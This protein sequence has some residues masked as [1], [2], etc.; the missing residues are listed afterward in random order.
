MRYDGFDIVRWKVVNPKPWWFRLAERLIPER[1]R[2][3]P[4]AYD[5]SRGVVLR[6]VA[7]VKR[8]VYLQQ[9]SGSEHPAWAHSHQWRRTFAIGL[10]GSYLE[11]RPAWQGLRLRRAPYFYTMDD[12]VIHRVTLPSPGH[13]S[14]FIGLWRNDDLKYYYPIERIRAER[15]RWDQHIKEMVRRI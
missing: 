3:I 2:E 14:V 11:L 1:T 6:Q 12:S 10:W 13:T 7:I 8:Y 9:F 15:V 5:P 4:E